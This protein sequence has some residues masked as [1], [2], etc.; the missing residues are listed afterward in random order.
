MLGADCVVRG[1]LQRSVRLWRGRGSSWLSPSVVGILEDNFLR[2]EFDDNLLC[3]RIVCDHK[4]HNYRERTAIQLDLYFLIGHNILIDTA[5]LDL[6]AAAAL[7]G[8]VTSVNDIM[9]IFGRSYGNCDIKWEK[10]NQKS[11]LLV[12]A[13]ISWSGF[14]T[15][16]SV[17]VGSNFGQWE[18]A[19]V[20]RERKGRCLDSSGKWNHN[21][22]ICGWSFVVGRSHFSATLLLI[23]ILSVTPICLIGS[24]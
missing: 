15:I 9:D 16:L 3:Y 11:W 18:C 23:W 2:G 24:V 22:I 4:N 19:L 5:P 13:A 14:S 6:T 21:I 17:A 7:T 8:H 10:W 20:N 12:A 1:S